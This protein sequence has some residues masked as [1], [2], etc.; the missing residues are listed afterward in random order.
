MIK[1]RLEIDPDQTIGFNIHSEEKA[2]SEDNNVSC[3][4]QEEL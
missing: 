1:E 3:V 2:S 4:E